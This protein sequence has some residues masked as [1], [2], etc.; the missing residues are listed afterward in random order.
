MDV[1]TVKCYSLTGCQSRC[2]LVVADVQPT[3]YRHALQLSQQRTQPA[4]RS[5]VA[6]L[7]VEACLFAMQPDDMGVTVRINGDG[8]PRT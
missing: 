6:A 4:V 2:I 8:I 1:R 7:M 3:L 5:D